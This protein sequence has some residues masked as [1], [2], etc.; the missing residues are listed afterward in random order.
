MNLEEY[1]DKLGWNRKYLMEH[2]GLNKN[3][4][5]RWNKVGLPRFV[6]LYFD[7][8]LAIRRLGR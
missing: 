3:T 8:L 4:L 5:V 6:V 7:L 1:L 2:F